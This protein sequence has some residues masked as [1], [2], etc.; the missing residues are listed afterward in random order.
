MFED[1]G[2]LVPVIR[3]G[4]TLI[5][6]DPVRRLV[7]EIYQQNVGSPIDL[8]VLSKPAKTVFLLETLFD[9]VLGE[10]FWGYLHNVRGQYAIETLHLLRETKA[11]QTATLLQGVVDFFENSNPPM[12]RMSR[13][14]K[15]EELGEPF[16][17]FCETSDLE[18]Y[19]N[20]ET[21]PGDTTKSENLWA[22]CLEQI[23]LHKTSGIFVN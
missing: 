23:D 14:S 2:P 18:F 22:I 1:S 21:H 19:R 12:D 16:F 15:M 8:N 11:M 4:D 7:H 10:G 5:H 20:V 13:T 17:R 6:R 3:I 9:G